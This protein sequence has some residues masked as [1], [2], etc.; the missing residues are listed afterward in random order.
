MAFLDR[1]KSFGTRRNAPRSMSYRDMTT[2]N[3]L[4]A[5]VGPLVA[6]VDRDL[7]ESRD[8]TRAVPSGDAA[9][10]TSPRLLLDVADF[11]LYKFDRKIERTPP[12]REA[13]PDDAMYDALE[14]ME[15]SLVLMI[16]SLRPPTASDKAQ[17][18]FEAEVWKTVDRIQE[19]RLRIGERDR[20]LS[21]VVGGTF[22]DVEGFRRALHARATIPGGRVEH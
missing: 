13:D 8:E 17:R 9:D 15:H 22:N 20:L 4:L 5:F 16:R 11:L 21:P 19:T 2:P 7:R 10:A 6:E 18:A 1:L 12:D 3:G 14:E